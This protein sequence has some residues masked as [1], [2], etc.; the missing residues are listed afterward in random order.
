M[1]YIIEVTESKVEQ[2]AENAEKML[3]YGGKVMQCIE[4][5]RESEG[6][7]GERMPSRDGYDDDDFYSRDRDYFGERRGRSMRTGR[8]IHR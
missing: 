2:L 3:R 4:E 8:Y 1:G 7:L 5:L 6:R